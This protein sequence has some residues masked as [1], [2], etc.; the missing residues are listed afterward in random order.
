MLRPILMVHSVRLAACQ[1]QSAA[2]TTVNTISNPSLRPKLKARMRQRARRIRDEN[3]ERQRVAMQQASAKIASKPLP[4]RLQ[5]QVVNAEGQLKP[6]VRGK[7]VMLF[8]E[9]GPWG[10]AVLVSLYFINWLMWYV[11]IEGLRWNLEGDEDHFCRDLVQK[12]KLEK[13][14]NPERLET[15][16]PRF[17]SLF[18]AWAA[19]HL[20]EPLRIAC[21]L[22]LTPFVAKIFRRMPK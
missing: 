10:I 15:L 3:R 7:I 13:L 21:A 1:L 9:Y 16:D 17:A 5:R 8:T 20:S 11:G 14:V 2:Y 4:P 12:L 19:N 18:L 22:V 6:T